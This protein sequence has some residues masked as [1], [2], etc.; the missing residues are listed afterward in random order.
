[1]PEGSPGLRLLQH[2]RDEA[3]RFAVAYHR[4][5]RERA[6]MATELENIPGVGPV[7]RRLLLKTF[8]SLERIRLASVD[9]LVRAGVPRAV[10]EAIK[11]HL[12]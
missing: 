6:G 7:R 12:G 9:E 8:G 1:L 11:E 5:R 10:A 4:L 2:I 3:H